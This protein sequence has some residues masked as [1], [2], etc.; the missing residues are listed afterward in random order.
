MLCD[1]K[2]RRIPVVFGVVLFMSIAG[3]DKIPFLSKYFP[4]LKSKKAETESVP[5]AVTPPGLAPDTLARVGTWTL[6][7]DEFKKE[8]RAIKEALPDFDIKNLDSKKLV[9]EQLIRQE[10]LVQEAEHSGLAQEKEVLEDIDK[11]RRALLVQRMVGKATEGVVVAPDEI[12]N[13]YEQNKDAIAEPTEWHIREI[14]V[15]T[16]TEA[17][18]I[19]VELLKGADFAATAQAKSKSPS[20]AKGGDLGFVTEFKFPEMQN[21]LATLSAGDTSNVFKGPGGYYVIK[22]EEKKGGKVRPLLELT[23]DIKTGLTISKQEKKML[24]LINELKQKTTIE[25]NED[26]LKE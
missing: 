9:L 11:F 4:S 26:L 5:P 16:Q 15:P 2:M 7:V 22:L 21:A 19:L 20:A 24:D 6:T 17:K 23:D 14:M 13:F 8:L 3:C 1:K 12:Q 18:D 25:T 10:L